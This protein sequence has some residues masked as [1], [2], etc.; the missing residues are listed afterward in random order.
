MH[1]R[2]RARVPARW[3]LLL[4]AASLSACAVSPPSRTETPSIRQIREEYF[5]AFPDGRYNDHIV[6]G[7]VVKGMSLFEVMASWGIPD[8][9][10]VKADSNDERWVY[11]LVDDR[12]LDWVRYDF[13][14]HANELMEWERTL[15]VA[16]GATLEVPANPSIPA[17]PSWP[18]ASQGSGKSIR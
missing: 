13:V 4:A 15:N 16:S 7:E 2:N 6:R 9:R 14:F 5:R 3:A 17:L 11:V 18:S 8:A 1:P 10:A 12:S